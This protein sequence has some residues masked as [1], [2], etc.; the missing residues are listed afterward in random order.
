[1]P[2]AWN[3]VRSKWSYIFQQYGRGSFSFSNLINGITSRFSTE[4]ELQELKNFKE[5][6]LHVGFGSAT[7]ALEQ[8]IEKTTANIKWVTENKAEVLKWLTDAT[9]GGIFS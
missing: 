8:A 2:L 4:F 7:M 1:M 6:N 3:F 9:R 5:D